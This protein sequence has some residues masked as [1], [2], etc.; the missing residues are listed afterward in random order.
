MERLPRLA[1]FTSVK[2]PAMGFPRLPS[3]AVDGPKFGNPSLAAS[4]RSK[5]FSLVP[6]SKTTGTGSL[7][8][9]FRVVSTRSFD[10]DMWSAPKGCWASPRPAFSAVRRKSSADTF[11]QNLALDVQF[12]MVI[13]ARHSATAY[14]YAKERLYKVSELVRRWR[15]WPLPNRANH[16]IPEVIPRESAFISVNQRL[17]KQT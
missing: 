11:S 12:P 17:K 9:T 15:A 7:P 8:A 4:F 1:P 10:W 14:G 5:M 13:R 6:V 3:M 2:N 16:Q